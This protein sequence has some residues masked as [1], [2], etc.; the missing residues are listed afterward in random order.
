MELYLSA[1]GAI[2]SGANLIFILKVLYNDIHELR[3]LLT[4]HLRD[5]A[6]FK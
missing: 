1:L 2:L 3:A 6:R 5:H 4:E